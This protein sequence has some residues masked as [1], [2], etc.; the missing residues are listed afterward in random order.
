MPYYSIEP[1]QHSSY[2][3]TVYTTGDIQVYKL[4]GIGK[5]PMSQTGKE[6]TPPKRGT[7]RTMESILQSLR[8]WPMLKNQ[9]GYNAK[10]GSR[11]ITKYLPLLTE[12]RLIRQKSS[13]EYEIT[14]KGLQFLKNYAQMKKIDAMC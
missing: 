5:E 2:I 4:L 3:G 8:E 12:M 10:L 1:Q 7:L 14:R 11:A 6:L 9:I 13:G